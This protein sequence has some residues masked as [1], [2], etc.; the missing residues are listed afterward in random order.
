M[1]YVFLGSSTVSYKS[2]AQAAEDAEEAE[3]LDLGPGF[4][5]RDVS[6]A[7]TAALSDE[8]LTALIQQGGT[9]FLP[10]VEQVTWTAYVQ[11][12]CRVREVDLCSRLQG[13]LQTGTSKNV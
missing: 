5:R 9:N 10:S 3:L 7:A 4:G 11:Q 8:A 6:R 12:C 13:Q 1:L 2:D